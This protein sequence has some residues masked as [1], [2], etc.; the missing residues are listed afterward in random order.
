MHISDSINEGNQKMDSGGKSL[1]VL[2]E[3]LNHK[4]LL[5]RHNPNPPIHRRNYLISP[6]QQQK[7]SKSSKR[8]KERKKNRNLLAAKPKTN[9]ELGSRP[10]RR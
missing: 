10:V 3:S 4:R 7:L 5:L 9:L 6:I 1:D 8:K 2:P